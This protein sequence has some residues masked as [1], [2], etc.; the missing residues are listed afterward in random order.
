MDC[1]KWKVIDWKTGKFCF[2]D[3]WRV[4][5]FA[6]SEFDQ[7]RF[8]RLTQTSKTVYGNDELDVSAFEVFG[9]LLE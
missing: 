4:E 2:D 7:S 5:S 1:G 8:M 9:T 3:G 6:V